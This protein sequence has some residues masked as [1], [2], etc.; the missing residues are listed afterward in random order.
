MIDTI[1]HRNTRTG[2]VAY[3][4]LWVGFVLFFVYASI[5]SSIFLNDKS[6]TAEYLKLQSN[7]PAM[8]VNFGMIFMLVIDNFW[9][10]YADNK[11]FLLLVVASVFVIMALYGH[12]QCYFDNSKN[13]I[14]LIKE[15]WIS[16]LLQSLFILTLLIARYKTIEI[17][18][19]DL[20]EV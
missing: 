1:I 15:S 17:I 18:K 19:D 12:A 6:F 5:V 9:H 20:E 16:Y 14:P 4:C 13:Y 3:S 7:I 11:Y 10:E 2:R 8:F